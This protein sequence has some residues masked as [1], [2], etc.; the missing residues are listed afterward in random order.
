MANIFIGFMNLWRRGVL[1]SSSVS[2]ADKSQTKASHVVRGV[3]LVQ[4]KTCFQTA[5]VS[6]SFPRHEWRGIR[7]P[8]APASAPLHRGSDRSAPEVVALLECIHKHT[9]SVTLPHS[10]CHTHTKLSPS[11]FDIST[12]PPFLLGLPP[13]RRLEHTSYRLHSHCSYFLNMVAVLNY[14]FFIFYLLP[15]RCCVQLVR[16][17]HCIVGPI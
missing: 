4:M 11:V 5:G 6:C 16:Y 7:S 3:K 12:D 17:Q 2:K 9:T 14:Y 13:A 8:P 10:R 1:T 15:A